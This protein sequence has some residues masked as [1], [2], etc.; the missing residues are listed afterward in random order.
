MLAEIL[1]SPWHWAGFVVA[2]LAFLAFDLGVFHRKAHRVKFQ[3]A[4]LWTSVWFILALLFAA[5]LAPAFVSEWGNEERAQFVT[6][7]ILELSLSMDNVFVM[8]LVFSYFRVPNEL[9]HRVLFWGILGALIMRGI[10]IW[11]GTELIQHVHGMLYFFGAFLLFTGVKMIF[12]KEEGIHPKR[13]PVVRLAQSFFPISNSFDGQKFLTRSDGRRMLTPLALVLLMV[14]TTDL[15]FALDSSPAIFGVTLNPFIVFTSNVFAILGLRSLYFVLAGALGY[16][17]YLKVGLSFVLI[18]I[19]LKML[20]P[21]V[22]DKLGL[23]EGFSFSTQH[24]LA[25]IGGIL[26]LSI[27]FSILSAW[28]ERPPPISPFSGGS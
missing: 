22:Q 4:L 20:L 24:S 10:M 11:I 5:V 15:V 14:E 21:L 18:F 17:R 23:L 25:V 6:G 2:I 12:I 7:Y 27:L 9:Q 13:N 19:G 8:A 26:L 3:E 28:R 16:F 1:I